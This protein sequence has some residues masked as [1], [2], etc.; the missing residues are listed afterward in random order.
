MLY[1]P[2]NNRFI[3]LAWATYSSRQK[4]IITS[5]VWSGEQQSLG[6]FHICRSAV[7]NLLIK[8]FQKF[9]CLVLPTSTYATA[10]VRIII[11]EI[12]PTEMEFNVDHLLNTNSTP[13]QMQRNFLQN[14]IVQLD[15]QILDMQSKILVLQ[16]SCSQLL[17]QR[18]C[19][20]RLLSPLR[21]LPIE[22]FGEIFMYATR[23]SPRHVL[24][25]SAVCQL[26][27]DA[28]L[29]TPALW[30]TLE[31]VDYKSKYN[32]DSHTDSWIK[33]ALSYPLSLVIRHHD[34]FLNPVNTARTVLTNH[35]CRSI[36]LDGDKGILSIL[37][38]LQFADLE[39]LESFSLLSQ[40]P[41]SSE[42]SIPDA[43]R[44]APKLKTLVLHAY[45][46]A[47]D[48]LPFPWRQLTSL[49]IWFM[50]IDMAADILRACVNLEQLII[51]Y[52]DTDI[53]RLNDSITLNYLRKLH[54]SSTYN[55]FLPFLETP[56]IQDF[57]I[58]TSGC[59]Y[60]SGV[61]RFIENNGSTLLKL[62]I[63]FCETELLDVIP[64]LRS[65]LELELYDKHCQCGEEIHDILSSLVVKSK[66]DY[67]TIPLPRLEALEIICHANED[68]QRMFMKVIGS[69][70]WSDEE[71]NVRRKQGVRSLSRIKRFVLSYVSA[72]PANTLSGDDMDF[73][74]E[75]GMSIEYLAPFDGMDEDDFYATTSS[76][77]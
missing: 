26:W 68:I 38:E 2:V 16:T 75:Q 57:S 56:S 14:F 22:I 12:V 64:C 36:T 40:V 62:S 46:S 76:F 34:G 42:L 41:D 4:N 73:L 49:I 10:Y 31:L 24:N 18:K 23:D 6:S 52:G 29:R 51:K 1:L 48:M 21:S 61:Y 65:L 19:Y 50:D 7:Y 72:V 44:Y 54:T 59:I 58:K 60:D 67:S 63:H 9:R 5:V 28:A 55:E 20:S 13:S 69:R 39:M 71:E 8:C 37:K 70:C 30:S 53:S 66:M 77:Y 45:H 32:M 27:R 35:K 17:Q 15:E 3:W 47:F 33:R 25:L 43:L 11:M 74:R